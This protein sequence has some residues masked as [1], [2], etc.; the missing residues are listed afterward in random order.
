MGQQEETGESKE[1]LS[2]FCTGVLSAGM[3]VVIDGNRNGIV[4]NV[5]EPQWRD[6]S[7]K[8]WKHE[9]QGADVILQGDSRATYFHCERISIDNGNN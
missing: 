4:S 8:S 3:R 1:Q 2:R 7:T 6:H 5:H 9:L